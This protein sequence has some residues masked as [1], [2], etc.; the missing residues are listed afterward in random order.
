QSD[1][2]DND[3][4]EITDNWEK[5]L[6]HDFS[7]QQSEEVDQKHIICVLKKCRSL[8]K[9]IRR[10]SILTSCFDQERIKCNK[11]R[12]LMSDVCTRWNSVFY[13][14]DSFLHLK[15]VVMNLFEHKHRLNIQSKQ[16]K[17]LQKLEISSNDWNIL[18]LLHDVLQPF[19]QATKL[20]SGSKY[21][22]IGL[23]YFAL[24]YIRLYLEDAK[25]DGSTT[26]RLKKL[27]LNKFNEYFHNEFDLSSSF[28]VR[29]WTE[30][31]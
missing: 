24:Y 19:Y 3:D 16:M 8:C 18:S 6:I 9:M 14:I 29:V 21:A 10:S 27:L 17:K 2:E 28:K 25:D 1:I 20:I 26:K 7:Y 22:T 31:S 23:I 15:Q 4:Y 30:K 12:I 11:K 5:N 13:M